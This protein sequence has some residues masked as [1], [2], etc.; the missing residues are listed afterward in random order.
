MSVLFA[1]TTSGIDKLRSMVLDVIANNSVD[2]LVGSSKESKTSRF[3]SKSKSSVSASASADPYGPLKLEILHQ[4]AIADE[5][6]ISWD[7]LYNSLVDYSFLSEQQLLS[8]LIEMV[9]EGLVTMQ[10]V[11]PPPPPPRS[12]QQPLNF[13]TH[14]DFAPSSELS[15]SYDNYDNYN[16]DRGVDYCDSCGGN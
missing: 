5:P 10:L 15:A 13:D 4:L 12:L 2:N 7:R 9:N 16:Y 3:K 11:P 6:T 1:L 14:L 8:L